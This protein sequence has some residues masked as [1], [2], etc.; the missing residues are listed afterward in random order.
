MQNVKIGVFLS[1][2][3]LRQGRWGW[4][5]IYHIIFGQGSIRD[6]TVILKMCWVKIRSCYGL[7][8]CKIPLIR[9]FSWDLVPLSPLLQT[10]L[11]ILCYRIH[12]REFYKKLH[13][14]TLGKLV[15]AGKINPH[16][17]FF[18]CFSTLYLSY[19]SALKMYH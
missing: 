18:S 8:P 16:N 6:K 7:F 13:Y 11:C 19:K 14:L 9:V 5:S 4:G 2:G 17:S 10:V 12:I 15:I 1:V 3:R